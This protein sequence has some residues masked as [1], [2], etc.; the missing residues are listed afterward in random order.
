MP[1]LKFRS[2]MD[3]KKQLAILGS[4]GILE[5]DNA[6][7]SGRYR[8]AKIPVLNTQSCIK[9]LF[10]VRDSAFEACGTVRTLLKISAI[11]LKYPSFDVGISCFH[12]E[13]KVKILA[14]KF[15]I[16]V[17]N[18]LRFRILDLSVKG[19]VDLGTIQVL[20]HQVMMFEDGWVGVAEC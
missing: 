2:S 9:R 4:H 17:K 10:V 5:L 14:F 15:T 11:L 18:R 3:S 20:R 19:R 16:L 13:N 1:N 7:V 6:I 12:G 8:K